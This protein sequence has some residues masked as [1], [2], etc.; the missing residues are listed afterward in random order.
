M[1]INP[2]IYREYDIRGVV[3][4]DLTAQVVYQLGRGIG[5][6]LGQRGAK[7]VAVGRDGR[8]SSPEFAE[9]LIAGLMATGLSVTDLS[10]APTPL[11][12]YSN[13]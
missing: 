2:N 11:V 1:K 8:N 9:S 10:V 12:Y 5:S 7:K 6:Y 13:H 3:G 4:A